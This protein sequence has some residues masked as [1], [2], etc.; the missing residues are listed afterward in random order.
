MT[1]TPPILSL[2]QREAPTDVHQWVNSTNN[3]LLWRCIR[4]PLHQRIGAT[5]GTTRGMSDPGLCA[6][7]GAAPLEA[8]KSVSRLILLIFVSTVSGG[9]C[10]VLFA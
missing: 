1:P 4:A 7:G 8:G 9:F 3:T 5:M 2:A 6:A 10:S